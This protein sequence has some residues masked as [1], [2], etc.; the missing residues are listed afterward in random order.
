M[1]H[2]PM[3]LGQHGPMMMGPG[4]LGIVFLLVWLVMMVGMV[5]SWVILIIAVWRGM[6][7]HESVA[8]SLKTIADKPQTTV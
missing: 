2:G 7:A 4:I 1:E 6:K 8:R 3:G 5:G